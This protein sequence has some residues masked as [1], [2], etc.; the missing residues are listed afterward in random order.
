[1]R[2]IPESDRLHALTAYERPLWAAG[3]VAGGMD[4]VGRGPLAG[5]VVAAVAVLPPEPLIEGVNDSKK[6]SEAKRMRLSAE[7]RDAAIGFGFGWVFPDVIDGINILQATY[8]AFALAY[9]NMGIECGALLM[10][11]LTVPAIPVKQH[12]I[13]HGDAS[14]YLIAA[15]S[16]IAKVERDEYM[17][18]LDGE[19]PMYGFAKNKGY[20]TP[21]HI[22]ALREYG[23]CPYH[24]RSFIRSFCG[25]EP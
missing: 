15:A 3:I 10:D 23:P 16:I 12:S 22:E 4:E 13:I 18:R 20:G 8:R 9:E 17:I 6:L 24:R 14:S 1:M 7:I 2:R 25:D 21:Q 19:Y 11:A 5:P